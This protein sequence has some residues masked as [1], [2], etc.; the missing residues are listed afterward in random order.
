MGL[1]RQSS[2]AFSHDH[3]YVIR[4]G[5]GAGYTDVQRLVVCDQGLQ[6]GP[7]YEGQLTVG[8]SSGEP[9]SRCPSIRWELH[10]QRRGAFYG[11]YLCRLRLAIH[12]Q[13][14]KIVRMLSADLNLD[15]I[16]ILFFERNSIGTMVLDD[17]HPFLKE[18]GHH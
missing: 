1:S 11:H 15:T 17:A 14:I 4:E 3:S 13:Q 18:E 6:E 10:I 12:H 2:F 7:P 16:S 9:P 5:K 8:R